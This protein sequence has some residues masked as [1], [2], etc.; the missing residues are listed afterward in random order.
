MI[1][2]AKKHWKLLLLLFLISIVIPVTA[3]S[4]AP[5]LAGK[6][7]IVILNALVGWPDLNLKPQT[8]SALW[9]GLGVGFSAFAVLGIPAI[10]GAVVTVL[11][12]N[13][14]R[15]VAMSILGYLKDR[16]DF[17]STEVYSEFKDK[18][19][20]GISEEECRDMSERAVRRASRTWYNETDENILADLKNAEVSQP[21]DRVK[22]GS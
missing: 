7:Q 9:T 17:I 15:S 18:L 22:S 14:K 11:L 19:K 16:D 13:A 12:E 6:N 10:L 2:W 4:L 20:A 21:R 1:K 3:G 5:V 8:I